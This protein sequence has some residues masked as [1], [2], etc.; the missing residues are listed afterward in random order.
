MKRLGTVA[1]SLLLSALVLTAAGFVAV[2][3][4][5]HLKFV[6]TCSPGSNNICLSILGAPTYTPQG[7]FLEVVAYTLLV[8][9]IT[10]QILTNQFINTTI[11]SAPA[12]VTFTLNNMNATLPTTF[13]SPTQWRNGPFSLAPL[14]HATGVFQLI[15]NATGLPQLG[16]GQYDV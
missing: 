2:S 5:I 12:G 15:I 4:T 11:F 9:S 16:A 7:A 6:I 10:S 3:N 1:A 14:G 8:T 13:S